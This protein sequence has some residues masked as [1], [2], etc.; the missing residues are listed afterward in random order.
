MFDQ[1]SYG[2]LGFGLGPDGRTIHYLTGGPIYIDGKRLA[3]KASTAMGEAKGIEDLHLVTFDLESRRY[4][5]HGAVFYRN[6]QRPLYV[7]SIAL[8]LDGMVYTLARI[9]EQGRT[10]SDLVAF[11]GPLFGH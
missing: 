1:F 8:G 6:H 2:Y 10:R 11:P 3:G 4:A 5:D 9:T 7:N